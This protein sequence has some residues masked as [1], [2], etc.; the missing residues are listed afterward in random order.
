MAAPTAELMTARTQNEIARLALSTA[1]ADKRAKIVSSYDATKSSKLRRQPTREMSNEDHVYPMRERVLGYNIG[2]DLER[3]YSP[4]RGILHQIRMNVVGAEG[5]LQ[6][7]TAKN[8]DEAAAWFN[9]VWAKDCDYR[10][11]GIHFSTQCQNVVAGAIRE[12]DLMAMVDDGLIDD[13]GKLIHWEADQI[14]PLSET[15][16]KQAGYPSD[17]AQENGII[18]DKWGKVLA[19]IVSGKRGLTVI[20]K[21]DATIL[22]P[23]DARLVKNPWRLNQ[24]RGVPALITSATNILDLYEI[25]GKE[26]I[27]AK[28][29]TQI[30]GVV[31]RGDA[32]TDFDDPTTG[33]AFLPENSDKATATTYAEGANSTD[34]EGKNYERF[35]ALTG[36]IFEYAAKGDKIE[37]PKIDRPNVA[38]NTFIEAVLGYAGASIGMARAYTILR[39]D[40]SYTS[41]RGDMILTWGGLFYP[42]QK[43][44]ERAYADWTA[45]K[46]LTWAQRKKK[47]K[48]L[49]AGWENK[50]SWKWPTMPS[51]DEA[52]ESVAQAQ[53]LKNGAVD[54][55]EILGPAWRVKFAAIAEQLALARELKL[56]L[57]I[58][59]QKS[60]GAATSETANNAQE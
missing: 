56:P 37:F 26:L 20:D 53:F 9:S 52:R 48:P 7:N 54:Y 27:S 32:V 4:A 59:E 49:E 40:S 5:K 15:G 12:G 2:R 30:A 35:E 19:Y 51:V 25:L 58:F 16:F 6:V 10:D 44:L 43:W 38:L 57:S 1:I 11:P 42:T 45:I 47:I 3:N 39:A 21:D 34:N 13:S 50:L 22:K 29:A 23:E 8:G 55:S 17:A 14:I 46:V 24:G 60:G 41:F 18:R 31:T 36:G 33:A 28:R